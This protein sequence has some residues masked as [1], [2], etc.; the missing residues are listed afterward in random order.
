M[1]TRQ[2]GPWAGHPWTEGS[3]GRSYQ[4]R[5]GSEP[6]R[7]HVSMHRAHTPL[8]TALSPQPLSRDNHAKVG[9]WEA[10]L[11]NCRKFAALTSQGR[12]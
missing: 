8:G 7:V 4:A 10:S 5:R 1:P 11:Q 3:G 6:A 12:Q 9:G 2:A